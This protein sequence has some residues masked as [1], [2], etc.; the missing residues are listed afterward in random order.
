MNALTANDEQNKGLLTLK[1]FLEAF[2]VIF[3]FE[4][5]YFI[6]FFKF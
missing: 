6:L 4:K 3:I 2:E 1:E 5:K